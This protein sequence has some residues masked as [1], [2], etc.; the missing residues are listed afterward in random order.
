MTWI[1]GLANNTYI[2]F[3]GL[4]PLV[5]I[6]MAF[7]LGARGNEWAWRNRRWDS[8]EHFERVQR[9]IAAW[10]VLVW[11]VLIFVYLAVSF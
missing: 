6:P 8:V 1:W 9:E 5:N 3:L 2:A 10:G 4:I 7:V 11:A